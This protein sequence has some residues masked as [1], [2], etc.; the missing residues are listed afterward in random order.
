MGKGGTRF[1]GEAVGVRA[2]RAKAGLSA[3]QMAKDMEHFQKTG[4][5]PAIPSRSEQDFGLP[6]LP[7]PII[8]RPHVFL[9]L[10]AGSRPLGRLVIEIYEELIPV[11]AQHF[12]NCCRPGMRDSLQSTPIR[13]ILPDL[14]F[15][16][17]APQGSKAP[18]HM[19]RNTRLQHVE[20]GCCSIAVT[21]SEFA[22]CFTRS[23][24]LDDTHQVVGRVRLGDDI[25]TE[26]NGLA[27]DA[28]DAPIQSL[29]INDCGLTNHEGQHEALSAE[30][31]AALDKKD[32]P[33]EAAAK[34]AA[35]AAAAGDSVREALQTGL[36][37]KR[38]AETAPL[39][40]GP[41]RKAMGVHDVLGDLSASA[42]SS[43]DESNHA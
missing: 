24:P 23:L 42:S 34:L 27:T 11:A 12:I 6:P 8:H 33:E 39:S 2:G 15:F 29:M 4:R 22:I 25:L 31:R 7:I 10:K 37:E 32:T 18:L 13:R 36:S 16:G 5:H 26:V 40:R 14:A 38:K 21:G 20:R 1:V 28:H 35:Q 19:R 9:D 17:G 3:K 41:K 30:A 43:S